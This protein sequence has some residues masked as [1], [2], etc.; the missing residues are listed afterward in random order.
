M[1]LGGVEVGS[2]ARFEQ[3]LLWRATLVKLAT[4]DDLLAT[5]GGLLAAVGTVGIG[6]DLVVSTHGWSP[7]PLPLIPFVLGIAMLIISTRQRRDA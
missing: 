1:R 5:L 4:L 3:G 2:L 6:W 7:G